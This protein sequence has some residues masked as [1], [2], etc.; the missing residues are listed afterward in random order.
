M[1]AGRAVAAAAGGS[2]TTDSALV[3]NDWPARSSGPGCHTTPL[4]DQKNNQ[5]AIK[6][7]YFREQNQ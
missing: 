4:A 5:E 7:S 3:T 1:R 6:C 2:D